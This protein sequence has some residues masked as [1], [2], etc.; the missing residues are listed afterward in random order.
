M[1]L[2]HLGATVRR[3][4][5]GPA[6]SGSTGVSGCSLRVVFE[7]GN[8]IGDHWFATRPLSGGDD[9]IAAGRGSLEL[10]SYRRCR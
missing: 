9:G 1:I 2:R 10:I 4:G 6:G 3:L 5:A 8:T 7:P